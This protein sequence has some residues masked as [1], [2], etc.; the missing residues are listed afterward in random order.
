MFLF[1]IALG[2]GIFASVSML[3]AAAMSHGTFVH[4]SV[5]RQINSGCV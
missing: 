4:V 1:G 5:L 3:V 2:F